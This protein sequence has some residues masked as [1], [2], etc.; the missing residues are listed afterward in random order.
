MLNSKEEEAWAEVSKLKHASGDQNV[1]EKPI[2]IDKYIILL[3]QKLE[4]IN[5]RHQTKFKGKFSHLASKENIV[6]VHK[7]YS[8]YQFSDIN[9]THKKGMWASF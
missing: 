9:L 5:H 1:H 7:R 3:V 8:S 6:M 4:T 2:V